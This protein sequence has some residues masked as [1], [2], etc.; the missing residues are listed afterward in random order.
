MLEGVYSQ[1]GLERKP[2]VTGSDLNVRAIRLGKGNP[3]P[4]FLLG[5]KMM[6]KFDR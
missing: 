5:G 1:H 6:G 4:L 3:I 2:W